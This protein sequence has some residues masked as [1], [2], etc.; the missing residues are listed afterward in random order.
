MMGYIADRH[1]EITSRLLEQ[2][3]GILLSCAMRETRITILYEFES[4]NEDS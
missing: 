3:Y 4:G 2:A 1:L